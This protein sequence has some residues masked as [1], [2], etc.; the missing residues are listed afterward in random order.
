MGNELV[1]NFGYSLVEY[2]SEN[3]GDS[4][5]KKYLYQCQIHLIIQ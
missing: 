1:Y 5:L 2:I 3:Y 4:S